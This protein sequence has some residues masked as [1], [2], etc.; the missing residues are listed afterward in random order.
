MKKPLA[1]TLLVLGNLAAVIGISLLLLFVALTLDV[2]LAIIIGLAVLTVLG[3][4]SSRI[5]K[6]FGRKYDMKRSRFILAA[7]VPSAAGSIIYLIVIC[8]LDAAGAFSGMF[9]GLLEFL[10][11]LSLVPTSLVYLISGVMWVSAQYDK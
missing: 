1:I 8:V 10:V 3:F 9:A 6:L 2:G 7:H 11:A 4:A 5:E